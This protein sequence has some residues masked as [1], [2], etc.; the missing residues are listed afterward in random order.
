MLARLFVHPAHSGCWRG[1]S[2]S[3]GCRGGHRPASGAGGSGCPLSIAG[4]TGP[5]P[6]PAHDQRA[7]T[8]IDRPSVE[9]A[10]AVHPAFG[11]QAD[12]AAK[13]PH[14]CAM[15]TAATT[16]PLIGRHGLSAG[17]REWRDGFVQSV[18]RGNVAAGQQHAAAL[19]DESRDDRSAFGTKSHP[20]GRPRIIHPVTSRPPRHSGRLRR[21]PRS[22]RP[23]RL[24][25]PARPALGNSCR[26]AVGR[27]CN[28]RSAPCR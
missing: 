14:H 26:A 12:T 1:C 25:V 10:T 13:G 3:A 9:P 17:Q 16:Q 8:P 22:R 7:T 28:P 2:P 18:L 4:P 15:A 24:R 27:T 20:R 19:A 21:C 23:A 6:R 5:V 11:S